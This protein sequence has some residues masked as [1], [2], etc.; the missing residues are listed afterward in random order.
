MPR[1]ISRVREL[2]LGIVV[3]LNRRF[4][5][6]KKLGPTRPHIRD[7]RAGVELAPVAVG[8]GI[9]PRSR[10]HTPFAEVFDTLFRRYP[11]RTF[12][13]LALMAAQAFFHN[14]ICFTYA[15]VLTR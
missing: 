2:S 14:A 15:L 4:A 3:L 5:Q 13:G 11:L 9:R 12:V 8:A 6:G 7:A 10:D 1:A